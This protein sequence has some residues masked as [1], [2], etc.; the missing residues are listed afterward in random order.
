MSEIRIYAACLASYNNGV[1][2][3]RWIDA[4]SD[5]ETMQSEIAEMLRESRFPN[6]TVKH[7]ETGEEVPSAEEWAMHDSEGLPRSFGEY[8]GLD[9]VAAFM[10]LVDEFDHMD[11]DDLAKIVDNWCGD[12]SE[13]ADNVRDNFAGIY[14]NF[15]AYADERAD[16]ML[17]AHDIK[18]DHPLRQ[19]FDYEYY[20]NDLAHSMTTVEVESGIAVFHN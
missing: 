1:L 17:D 10:E 11:S 20:S 4:D 13:A 9:K 15:K 7:P 14:D 12:V 19:Y 16:E 5:V 3:G 6:V 2:H 8:C 18:D